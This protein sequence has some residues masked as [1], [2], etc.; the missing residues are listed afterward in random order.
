MRFFS[1]ESYLASQIVKESWLTC[2]SEEASFEA[3]ANSDCDGS[4]RLL[5]NA[6]D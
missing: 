1:L 2:S 5:S 4:S 6:A 3:N